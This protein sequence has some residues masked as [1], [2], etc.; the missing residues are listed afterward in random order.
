MQCIRLHVLFLFYRHKPNKWSTFIFASNRLCNHFRVLTTDTFPQPFIC[1]QNIGYS[2][3]SGRALFKSFLRVFY[4]TKRLNSRVTLFR[5]CN[6]LQYDKH[7]ISS[8][9]QYYTK[10][11]YVQQTLHY[12]YFFFFFLHEILIQ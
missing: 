3:N 2:F 7:T 6:V 4:I 10:K 11:N 5:H 12:S 8:V 9:L 1:Q